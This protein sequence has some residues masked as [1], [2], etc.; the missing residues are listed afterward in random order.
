M[1]CQLPWPARW[2]ATR[3]VPTAADSTEA[4]ARVVDIITTDDPDFVKIIYDDLPPGSPHLSRSAL[5]G[6]IAEATARGVRA[7]VHATTPDD[8]MEAIAARAA[9]M[10]HIPQRGV[11]TDDQVAQLATSGGALCDHRPPRVGQPRPGETGCGA[12]GAT[13]VRAPA[14][15][16]LAG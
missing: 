8:V 10:T 9:L 1:V 2:F 5:H 14:A 16:T 6:A 11:L 13:D 4:R 15:P 3:S 7:L 12:A